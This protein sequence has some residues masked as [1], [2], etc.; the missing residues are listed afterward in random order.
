M[1]FQPIRLVPEKEE[2]EKEESISDIIDYFVN[3]FKE[4]MV[5]TERV[6]EMISKVF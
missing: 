5:D 6:F 1:E 3:S 2:E 4:M